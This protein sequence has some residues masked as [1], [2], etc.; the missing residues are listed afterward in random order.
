MRSL[1]LLLTLSLVGARGTLSP[2]TLH[3]KRS[4]IPSGWS[5]AQ[6]HEPSA[7]IPLRIALTQPN[8]SNFEEYLHDV[9]HPDSPN[10]GKHWTPEE[11]AVRFAPSNESIS[12]VHEWLLQSGV[13]PSRVKLSP[14][15][16][17]LHVNS[18]V[19]EAEELL[20]TKYYVYDHNT[21]ARHV[22]CES[23]HLPA[24]VTP[25]IDF[26]TPTIHFDAK[27]AVRPSHG[28]VVNAAAK[29]NSDSLEDCDKQMTPA[30]LRA[31]YGLKDKPASAKGNSFGIVQYPPQAYRQQDLD[32]FAKKFS[33]GLDG[34]APKVISIDGGT[35]QIKYV[36]HAY[37]TE[38]SLDLEYAM[39]LVGPKQKV[40][41]YE[42]G[43]MIE[44]ASYNN[45]LDAIDGFYCFFMD[46][47]DSTFDPVYPDKHHGGY[48]GGQ[49][50]GTTKPTNVISTSYGWDEHALSNLYAGRQCLEYGKLGLMGITVLYPSGDNG[51]AAI[52]QT[53]TGKGKTFVPSFP[54]TCPFVTSV[55]A[56]QVS[57]GKSV[58]DPESACDAAQ[59]GVYSGGGWSNYFG[60]PGYQADAVKGYLK[61][62]RPPY[63]SG[64]WNSTGKS[65]AYPDMSANG[66]N[67]LIA[68]DN[69]F[70]TASGTSAAAPVVG[71]I[72]TM[73]NDARIAAGKKPVGFIN[74]TIYS[75]KFAQGF[76]DVTTGSNPGCDTGGFKA[77]K[78]WDPVT[79]LGT[80]NF[81][82]L[83]EAWMK[84]P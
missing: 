32:S 23:Y 55:G 18:T 12:T 45:F 48:K 72:L 26:V 14:G 37:N 27:V 54:S 42:V 52:D 25:H 63:A 22:A 24:H 29:K 7:M 5:R 19:A 11:V 6:Q 66:A 69:E 20:R 30:C 41:L 80:P 73:V 4:Q 3:E 9:S 31:L 17:W 59:A 67:Y 8:I 35:D 65:R 60:M 61:H 81:P 79:G 77:A 82:K 53:C 78:G 36:G 84:L 51:V 34:V 64:I 1:P 43:D 58:H 39:G 70:A 10:Y 57:S 21:G 13:D 40:T 44:G 46:G 75:K 2:W 33:T 38:S 50:C 49:P 62:H 47:D 28:P 16:G 15:R 83:V 74:P 68:I 56:T 76:H 71:A